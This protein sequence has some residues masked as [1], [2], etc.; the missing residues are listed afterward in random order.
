MQIWPFLTA[1]CMAL[2]PHILRDVALYLASTPATS[3]VNAVQLSVM[4]GPLRNV[5][6]PS[7]IVSSSFPGLARLT[8]CAQFSKL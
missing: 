4:D 6:G 8:N 3:H 5:Y 2:K 7:L 1:A